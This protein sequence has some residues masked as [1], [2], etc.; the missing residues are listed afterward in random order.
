MPATQD[1]GSMARVSS[2]MSLLQMSGLRET[3]VLQWWITKKEPACDL[4]RDNMRGEKKGLQQEKEENQQMKKSQR[5]HV[6]MDIKVRNEKN[7]QDQM[8]QK[9]EKKSGR[10][11]ISPWQHTTL[12]ERTVPKKTSRKGNITS[13]FYFWQNC[14]SG[15]TKKLR[16]KK[17][18]TNNFKYQELKEYCS[19]EEFIRRHTMESLRFKTVLWAHYIAN[20]SYEI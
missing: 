5:K 7:E 13:Q 1:H 11:Q 9:W 2:D 17:K 19:P 10:P 16:K 6:S 18:K 14:S 20:E 15:K 12:E 4:S 3:Y 8:T